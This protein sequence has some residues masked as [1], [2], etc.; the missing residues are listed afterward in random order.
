MTS[1]ISLPIELAAVA[2]TARIPE[3]RLAAVFSKYGTGT[4]ANHAEDDNLHRCRYRSGGA[5]LVCDSERP[6]NCH[7][8]SVPPDLATLSKVRLQPL[9]NRGLDI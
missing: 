5:D 9:P 7:L 3:I 1:C 4:W 2:S 8:E 6:N